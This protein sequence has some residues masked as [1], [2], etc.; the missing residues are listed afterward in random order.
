MNF[1]HNLKGY[2]KHSFDFFLPPQKNMDGDFFAS[3]K[4]IWS[5]F[6]AEQKKS[7]SLIEI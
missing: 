1:F 3:A 5:D 7:I 4:K 2:E 6:F